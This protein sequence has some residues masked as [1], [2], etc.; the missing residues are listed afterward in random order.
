MLQTL[1]LSTTGLCY[2]AVKKDVFEPVRWPDPFTDAQKEIL[3]S[4]IFF[5]M[6]HART[7]KHTQAYKLY[8]QCLC[9]CSADIGLVEMS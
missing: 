9:C 8:S 1:R 7:H 4:E 3:W 2:T 5:L 6:P